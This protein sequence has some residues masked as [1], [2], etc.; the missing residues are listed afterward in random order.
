MEDIIIIDD[1]YY[2]TEYM[3]HILSRAFDNPK[4]YT[5][6]NQEYGLSHI[7]LY[8]DS[9][10]LLVLDWTFPMKEG[11]NPK[12]AQ[13]LEVLK[14]LKQNKID[15]KTII[16]SCD[17]IEL[18]EKFNNVVSIIKYCPYKSIER[19]IQDT[20]NDFNKQLEREKKREKRLM[21]RLYYTGYKRKKSSEPWWK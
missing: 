12:Y 10:D 18:T 21:R 17:D 13:G 2:K 19:E 4:I 15:I 14:Y 3:K 8:R 11:E 1:D 9:I 7:D 20:V 6:G 16:F 5:Y